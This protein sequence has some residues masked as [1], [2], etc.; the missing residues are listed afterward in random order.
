M[1]AGFTQRVAAVLGG[2][3]DDLRRYVGLASGPVAEALLDDLDR[4]NR[5]A[6][7]G[8]GMVV[9]FQQI[10][11]MADRLQASAMDAGAEEAVRELAS[12]GTAARRVRDAWVTARVR[13]RGR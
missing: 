8:A 7:D 1:R 10:A 12:I 3:L 6:S 13:Q 5:M 4:L 2:L 11:L 9:L